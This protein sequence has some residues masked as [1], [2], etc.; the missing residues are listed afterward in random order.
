MRKIERWSL[1]KVKKNRENMI[2]I[3]Y[4]LLERNK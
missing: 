3:D 1:T 4:K 2:V